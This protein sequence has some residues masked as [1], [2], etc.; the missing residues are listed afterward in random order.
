[1]YLIQCGDTLRLFE[2]GRL[3]NTDLRARIW[4]EPP[5]GEKY[6]YGGMCLERLRQRTTFYRGVNLRGKRILVTGVS[7]GSGY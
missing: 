5:E 3:V 4:G 6:E 7:A 1:V 2:M